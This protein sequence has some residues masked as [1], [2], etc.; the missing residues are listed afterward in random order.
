LS[1]AVVARVIGQTSQGYR[2]RHLGLGELPQRP[3]DDR[4]QS[5]PVDPQGLAVGATHFDALNGLAAAVLEQQPRRGDVTPGG[6]V[7]D[8]ADRLL[9]RGGLDRLEH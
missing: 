1:T 2:H 7:R 5:S 9:D 8:L 4:L 6:Q 3:E